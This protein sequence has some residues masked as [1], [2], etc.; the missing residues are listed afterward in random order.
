MQKLSLSFAL[1]TY[2]GFWRPTKWPVHSIKY[3]L[4]N[5]Y[6]ALMILFLYSFT[7][8]FMIDCLQF[9]DMKTAVHK[10]SIFISAAGV[11]VKVANVFYQRDKII[12]MVN[13]LVQGNCLPKDENEVI[14]Q[15]KF[16]LYARNLTICCE[17][18][19]ETTAMFASVAQF[20]VLISTRTLPMYE[21]M[22]F[23]LEST[24]LYLFSLL[25][26]SFGVLVCANSS[27]ANETLISGLMIQVKA[28]F[29]I[30]CHRA[31]KLPALITEAKEACT[32]TEDFKR[33]RINI[34]GDLVKNHLE[35]YEFATIVNTI[36]QYMIFIQFCISVMVVCLSIYTMS[37]EPSFD[38]NFV[39][40]FSYLCSMMMQVH[41][42]CWY[43]NEVALQSKSVGNAIYEMDWTS[44][45]IRVMKD[46]LIIMARSSKPTV[47]SS[48]HVVTLSTDSFMAIMKMSYSTY[49]LLKDTSNK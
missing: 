19:N 46:L 27:V 31:R 42:Y 6:S 12:N 21:W 37:T 2:V 44:L 23:S 13:T 5:A 15:R 3:W 40:S 38:I 9:A 25:F 20:N 30:F 45:P 24:K 34:L 22:P 1:L 36:F 29:E 4:Y 39:S 18:L 8:F 16:D 32:S 7:L 47:M 43:G 48:G 11:C 41:L 28:Q 10:F 17:I 49:N 14:I 26:Q 35:V 33:K